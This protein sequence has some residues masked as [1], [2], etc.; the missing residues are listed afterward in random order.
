MTQFAARYT[1]IPGPE[2]FQSAALSGVTQLLSALL[3]IPFGTVCARIQGEG[4]AAFGYRLDGTT[5]ST[6]VQAVATLQL[7]N[8]A[9]LD[10][11][12]VCSVGEAATV[13]V[14]FFQGSVGP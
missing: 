7:T 5:G 6:E 14:Q 12:V 13:T 9:Q 11:L 10:E 3:D 8:R 1:P 4:D 2:G